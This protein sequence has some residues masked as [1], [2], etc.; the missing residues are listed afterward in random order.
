[1]MANS[2][3]SFIYVV[4]TTPDG[5]I[6]SQR[7]K[8]A[9]NWSATCTQ[10]EL[11]SR[12]PYDTAVLSVWTKFGVDRGNNGIGPNNRNS[13][14]ISIYTF[15]LPTATPIRV[16]DDMIIAS[17]T[18]KNVMDRVKV[19]KLDF[20]ITTVQVLKYLDISNLRKIWK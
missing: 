19:N 1:M 18:F 7:R 2:Y 4:V 6:V 15:E 11:D 5:R 16:I 8:P 3:R 12:D 10:M 20:S 13:R 9:D 17:D 14:N